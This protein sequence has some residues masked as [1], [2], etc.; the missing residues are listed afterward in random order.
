M[1]G[2]TTCC[3]N[4]IELVLFDLDDTI[5]TDGAKLSPRVANAIAL[6]RERGAMACVSSGRPFTMVPELLRTP[7]GM[8]YLI[9]VNGAAIYDTMGDVLRET[10][11]T[12]EQAL[13]ALNV[14]KPLRPGWNCFIDGEAYFEWRGFSYIAAGRTPTMGEL[15]ASKGGLHT[16]MGRFVR[17]VYRFSKRM[18]TNR[19]GR[20]QVKSIR[21]AVEASQGVQKLGC[22]FGNAR[23]C[24][25]AVATLEHLGCYEVARMGRQ[26]LEITAAGVTK[27]TAARWLMDYLKVDP[28]RA[29]A[30]GDSDNDAPLAEACG[31]FVAME[32]A[33]DAIKAMADDV[34]ESVYD[35]GV[36]RWL[37]RAMHEAD[38]AKHV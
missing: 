11:L 6:A 10:P 38:G 30:F 19:T 36:A 17:K 28:A 12:R 1:I 35:D 21:P 13:R 26:E 22:S 5:L 25:R 20:Y 27:A 18:I 16:G 37:E 33:T 8:D 2:P 14:L 32:N 23:A 31:T 29:V 3:P 9:C 24:D 4:G 7:A 34:C 15:K